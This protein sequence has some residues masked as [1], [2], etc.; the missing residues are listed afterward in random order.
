MDKSRVPDASGW[1]L[2][3]GG[4]HRAHAPYQPPHVVPEARVKCLPEAFVQRVPE[5]RLQ[6]DGAC[7]CACLCA[8]DGPFAA[9]HTKAFREIVCCV[10]A[11]LFDKS[12]AGQ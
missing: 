9:R 11:D 6:C 4:G 3:L 5:A 12:P 8:C 2:T 10:S 7:I 1:S